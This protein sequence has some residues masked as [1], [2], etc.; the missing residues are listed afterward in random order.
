M[1]RTVLWR[2]LL[3]L[4]IAV[5]GCAP[6]SDVYRDR[7]ARISATSRFV[8]DAFSGRWHVVAGYPNAALPLCDHQVWDIS[9]DPATLQV[10]CGTDRR[11]VLS[12]GLKVDPRGVMRVQT[13]DLDRDRYAFWVLWMD[14][15]R[16]MAVIGTR[17]GEMGWVLNRGA[18][19]R[20]DRLAAAQEI[21]EFNGYDTTRLEG[22]GK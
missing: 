15:E 7:D 12:A 18:T 17:G 2:G 21:L 14:E 3:V 13:A 6:T 11:V 20:A 16:R 1:A 19:I 10:T 5:A 4:A 8:P 22:Q 9:E